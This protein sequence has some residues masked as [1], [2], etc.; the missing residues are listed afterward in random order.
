[1]NIDDVRKRA[2]AMPPAYPPGPAALQLFQ[3]ALAPV[4][5]AR[6]SAVPIVSD[7]TLGLGTVVCD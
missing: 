7:L 6:V 3:H 2:Y 5:I 4:A 1:M